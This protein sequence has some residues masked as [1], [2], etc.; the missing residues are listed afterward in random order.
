[1]TKRIIAVAA[2]L[3]LLGAAFC[4]SYLLSTKYWDKLA[5]L[6]GEP[7]A[8]EAPDATATDA[9]TT[10]PASTTQAETTT[11][12]TGLPT[13]TAAGETTTGEA[14]TLATET[15]VMPTDETWRIV[16]LNRTHKIADGYTPELAP[17]LPGSTVQV[18]RRVAAAFQEMHDDA[19]ADGVDLTPVS[20]YVST[21]LQTTLYEKKVE[22]LMD[23]GVAEGS[24]LFLAAES[25]LP[26]GCCEDNIGIS[27]S[28]GMQLDSF[29]QTDAYR[30]LKD[31]AVKYGFIER[32]TAEKKAFTQVSPRPWYW[33]YVGKSEAETIVGSGLCLEEFLQR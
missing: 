12:K 1:M 18:D 13:T 6:V 31:N 2:I 8:T 21:E 9:P 24:T 4:A 7:V 14:V 22:E 30:W 3:V 33:R 32:Y 19:A 15:V 26:G 20:G 28:I 25:V 17:A 16:L 10:R 23:Q 27:V 11:E 5:P 29:A